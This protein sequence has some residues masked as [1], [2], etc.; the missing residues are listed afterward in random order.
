MPSGGTAAPRGENRNF[1]RPLYVL[2]PFLLFPVRSPPG[3]GDLRGRPRVFPPLLLLSFLFFF[4]L[5]IVRVPETSPPFLLNLPL[6]FSFP[7]TGRKGPGVTSDLPSLFSTPWGGR[8]KDFFGHLSFFPPFPQPSPFPLFFS[9]QR[10]TREGA[11]R[12]FPG[13]FFLG[14]YLFLFFSFFG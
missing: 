10:R 11:R 12:R 9:H 5:E 2:S 6:P 8:E 3:V 14:R 13:L 1:G 4:P 7:H